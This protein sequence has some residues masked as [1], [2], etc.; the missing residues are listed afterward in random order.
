[1]RSRAHARN[2]PYWLLARPCGLW[3]YQRD[4]PPPRGQTRKRRKRKK[5]QSLLGV[6]APRAKGGG[7]GGRWG[8]GGG[9]LSCL[10]LFTRA[11][12]WVTT[13]TRF[14]DGCATRNMITKKPNMT[15]RS[16]RLPC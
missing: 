3:Q 1:M 14:V 11:R 16:L 8:G 6:R 15:K 5:A 12:C 9:V 7:G 10:I 13:N 2:I 4:P